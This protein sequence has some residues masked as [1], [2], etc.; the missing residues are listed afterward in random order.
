M[1]EEQPPDAPANI[2]HANVALRKYHR[3][4]QK[5]Y[6]TRYHSA[7]AM[8]YQSCS[9]A[10]QPIVRG[11][12]DPRTM[13]QTL[14]EHLD[15]TA[16]EGGSLFIRQQ[17]LKERYDGKS[18]ITEFVSRLYEFRDQL[19]NTTQPLADHELTA[20]ILGGLPESWQTIKT[21]ILN[22]D[23]ATR[24]TESIVN[25]LSNHEAEQ[26]RFQEMNLAP[27]SDL[28]ATE[29]PNALM[30]AANSNH[31]NSNYVPRQGS[32]RG[33]GRGRRGY[34]GR[35]GNRGG[36]ANRGKIEKPSFEATCWFCGK[37]NHKAQECRI[38][39]SMEE[40]HGTTI[41]INKNRKT[42]AEATYA[43]ATYSDASYAECELNMATTRH[44]ATAASD[45]IIDSGA[46]DHMCF[47][48]AHFKTLRPLST[49]ITV[50]MGNGATSRATASGSVELATGSQQKL[51]LTNVLLVPDIRHNL[52][53]I[54]RLAYKVTFFH[55]ECSIR[56]KLGR[57]VARIRSHEGLYRLRAPMAFAAIATATPASI[58]LWHR[59]LGHLNV[60]AVRQLSKLSEGMPIKDSYNTNAASIC[61]ACIEG[62]QHRTF[63][64]TPSNRATERLELIHSDLSGPIPTL[65][66]GRNRYFIVYIDDYSRMTWIRF[67]KTKEADEVSEVFLQYKAAV[68]TASG[69]KIRRFRCDNGRGEY[70]N[71]TF[72]SI[73]IKSGIS[74][75]PSAPHTQNQNGVSER[76]IR[77]IV[78]R[79]RSMLLDSRLPYRFWAEAAD[80]ATYLINR[81]PTKAL[82]NRTPYETW[83]GYKPNNVHLR[84]FGCDAYL[85]LPKKAKLPAK[86]RCCTLIGYIHNPA[87]STTKLWK[88]W[89]PVQK[90]AVNGANVRFDESNSSAAAALLEDPAAAAAGIDN[91]LFATLWQVEGAKESARTEAAERS[92]QSE[93]IAQE[94]HIAQDEHIA[95]SEGIAQSVGAAPLGHWSA[96]GSTAQES[97]MEA[98]QEAAHAEDASIQGDEI[99]SDL[100]DMIRV[101]P[102]PPQQPRRRDAMLAACEPC[103]Y[104][105]PSSYREAMEG[106]ERIHWQKAIEEE[107]SSLK[108]NNTWKLEKLPAGRRAIASMWVFKK[109]INADGTLRYKARLVIKGCQQRAG[110]DYNETCPSG[111]AQNGSDTASISSPPQVAYSSPRRHNGVP[112]PGS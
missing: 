107:Y 58:D 28:P 37:K 74:Y 60:A 38:K 47:Q 3:D 22:Q 100:E 66:L 79:F 53:A 108:K 52:I 110:I 97:A 13:W 112:E 68:E 86:S 51:Q 62:K 43:E 46:T 73:L 6:E 67:L 90:A 61:R 103:H 81:S 34:R 70:F 19:A 95:R 10:I 23:P 4:E 30:A 31:T 35:G 106:P 55:G 20:Y 65:S 39:K 109:K 48:K 87:H 92:A 12:T 102:L 63:N 25:T 75:E 8:I 29:A 80:T 18:S 98:M 5:D 78:E 77:T 83:Y 2:A 26:K 93:H 94:E 96:G 59:R 85:I 82:Q 64:R 33:N 7:A 50:R 111:N 54:D 56:D 49:P 15:R 71:A 72:K 69:C 41:T 24:T 45:W 84:K 1:G 42:D 57:P 16:K 27:N 101:E 89:D 14:K 32:G 17:L 91:A 11:M 88:L 9:A 21:V 44:N 99:D 36:S 40:K 76:K 104:A 105:E